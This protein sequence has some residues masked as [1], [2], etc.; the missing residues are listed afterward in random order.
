MKRIVSVS[1]GSPA[2]NA[3]ITMEILGERVTLSRVGTNGDLRAARR[4]VEELDG[5][6]DAIGLGGVNLWLYAGKRRYPVR[7]ARWLIQNVRRTPVVDGSG[8][9]AY[10]ERQLP[11]TIRKV[12]PHLPQKATALVVSAVDRP[13][14]Y[15]ALKA[16]GFE[17]ILGDIAVALG[18]PFATK[19][20]RLVET[21]ARAVVPIVAQLP[22]QW[23]YPV[24]E[25]QTQIVRGYAT[26][27]ME[28][29]TIIA[30]DFHYI[31]RHLPDSLMNKV[32]ITNTVTK[33]DRELLARRGP[34]FLIT[35][36]PNFQGRS[37]ATNVIEALIVAFA[38]KPAPEM[39]ASDYERVA[40]VLQ[41]R[42]SIEK[43]G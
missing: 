42:P 26:R 3:E 21:L 20:F 37:F 10:I 2:R 40:N 9:K 18:I 32:I 19:S 30:G 8:V 38:G 7:Q 25:K 33:E 43:L 41:I 23:V 12:Q 13:F 29:A 34:V 39:T 11:A 27:L 31:R 4:L 28:R 15:D 24:G 5:T 16:Q 6:V 17:V 1:L 36:S 35:T 14:L 22:I